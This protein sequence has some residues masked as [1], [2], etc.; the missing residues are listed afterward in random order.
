[1]GQGGQKSIYHFNL[2]P[3]TELSLE[4]LSHTMSKVS[5]EKDVLETPALHAAGKEARENR[6]QRG[7]H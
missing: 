4:S 6:K 3:A 2:P 7:K 1:M 5:V